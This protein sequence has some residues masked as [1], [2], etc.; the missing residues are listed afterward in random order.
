LKIEPY[1]FAIRFLGIF[2]GL[3]VVLNLAY[4]FWIDRQQN[5]ADPATRLVSQH[6]A[7]CLRL[8]GEEVVLEERPGVATVLVIRGDRAVLEVFEG[9]NGLNV[10]IVFI[11]FLL[12][13]GGR[14]RAL[15]WFLPLGLGLLHMANV[16][17]IILLYGVALA[18]AEYFYWVHK[19]LFTA[20]L[21]AVVFLL[22][23]IWIE[24][25]NRWSLRR[26]VAP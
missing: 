5:R 1:R 6:T 20:T 7:W 26:A 11:S 18:Y 12:A 2:L 25:V 14:W 17:R 10:M 4:Q 21:Y 22:W 13:F 15:V 3:Y 16:A 8:S 19:Y 24:R 9:C 23:W